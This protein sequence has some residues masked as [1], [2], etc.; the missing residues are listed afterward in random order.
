MNFKHLRLIEPTLTWQTAFLDMAADFAAA[1]DHRYQ[2]ASAD[3][4]TYIAHLQQFAHGVNLPS[5][6]VPETTY[7]GVDGPLMIGCIRLRHNLTPTLQ[8][9]GGHIGYEIRPAK[10]GQGYGTRMLAL[11]LERVWELGLQRVLITCDSDNIG[12]ARIIEK[13]GGRLSEQGVVAGYDKV[14][15]RYWIERSPGD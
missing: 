10:R 2:T 9:I 5:G 14:I 3:F 15:L 7:W 1:N 4:P 13:N 12:S 11:A 8:Q 6:Y